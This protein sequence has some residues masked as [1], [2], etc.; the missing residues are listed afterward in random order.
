MVLLKDPFINEIVFA[1]F[2][3]LQKWKMRTFGGPQML[4]QLREAISLPSLTIMGLASFSLVFEY[5]T[6]IFF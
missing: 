6:D 3:P 2:A 1:Y 5:R 4:A